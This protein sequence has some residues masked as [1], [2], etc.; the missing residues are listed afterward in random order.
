MSAQHDSSREWFGEESNFSRRKGD[1]RALSRALDSGMVQ[2]W[3]Y[4]SWRDV[5][6][7]Q[8]IRTEVT[9]Q[10]GREINTGKKNL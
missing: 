9:D 5:R 7:S 8:E 2:K 1:L 6:K 4:R 3:G 10:G